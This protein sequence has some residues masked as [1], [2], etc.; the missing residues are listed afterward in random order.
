MR[1]GSRGAARPPCPR[2]ALTDAVADFTRAIE[3]DPKT[4]AYP[5]QRAKAHMALRQ[6][7]LARSDLD[8]AIALKPDLPEALVM[9]ARL[10]IEAKD[11]AGARADFEAAA[12]ADPDARLPMAGA[13]INAGEF[14]DAISN[15][16]RWIAANPR[17]GQLAQ[18][19]DMRCGAR[20]LG[21][22]EPEQGLADCNKAV[23]LSQ[24]SPVFLQTRG[25]AH[26]RLGQDD[27]AIADFDASL[28][29]RPREAWCLYGKGLAEKRKGLTAQGEADQK[30]AAEIAPRLAE[31]AKSL[32]FAS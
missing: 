10:R 29:L 9:R 16:D 31:R 19:L 20:T 25:M 18:A 4:A 11:M 22:L 26:L 14:A 7:A 12:A 3:L 28:K 1:P 30:A 5:L 27:A 24:G 15:L 32:G 8:Q 17:N 23:R 6:P 13:L 21:N 2:G